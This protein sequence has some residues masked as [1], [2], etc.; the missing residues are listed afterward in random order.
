[1]TY[2]DIPKQRKQQV[3][4]AASFWSS[5]SSEG[6]NGTHRT[7]SWQMTEDA[8]YMTGMI[9]IPQ[10]W[11]GASDLTFRPIWAGL[12]SS[13]IADTETVVFAGGWYKV[14]AGS[15]YTTATLTTFAATYTQSGAGTGGEIIRSVTFTID[16]DASGNALSPGDQIYIHFRH[17]AAG[18]YDSGTAEIVFLGAVLEWS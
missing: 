6:T 16:Y 1:M 14:A 5:T 18:T 12:S 8:D 2:T 7:H 17:T 10:T 13:A 15:V 11:N 4:G 3:Y 9:E